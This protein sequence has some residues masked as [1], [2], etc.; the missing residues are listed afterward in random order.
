MTNA[1]RTQR[2]VSNARER[3]EPVAGKIEDTK[4]GQE[5]ETESPSVTQTIARQIERRQVHEVP[6]T[7]PWSGLLKRESRQRDESGHECRLVL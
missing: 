6:K 4:T 2:V 1:F 7:G 5:P 3:L